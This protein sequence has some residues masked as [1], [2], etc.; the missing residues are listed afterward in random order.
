MKVSYAPG[1][2][3]ACILGAELG[4]AY[5]R[6]EDAVSNT[7][8]ISHAR[9]TTFGFSG[10]GVPCWQTM[11]VAG[12]KNGLEVYETGRSAGVGLKRALMA[13]SSLR[14]LGKYGRCPPMLGSRH[15][16]AFCW[17]PLKKDTPMSSLLLA[18]V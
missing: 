3:H 6:D 4:V 8:C 13:E 12:L 5:A 2:A 9:R 10:F 15:N 17:C 18:S 11:K 16:L 7:L 1:G 14:V